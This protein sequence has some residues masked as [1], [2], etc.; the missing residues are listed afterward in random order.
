MIRILPKLIARSVHRLAEVRHELEQEAAFGDLRREFR[1]CRVPERGV[2]CR[3]LVV[4][5]LMVSTV[6]ILAGMI[7]PN[8]SPNR[9]DERGVHA[10]C[11]ERVAE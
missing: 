1:R 4:F 7:V 3:L 10:V 8:A 2:S 5:A 6:A 9:L 11:V